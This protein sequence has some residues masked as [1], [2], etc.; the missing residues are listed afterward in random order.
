[1][2]TSCLLEIEHIALISSSNKKKGRSEISW[3]TETV[4]SSGFALLT[5]SV[6]LKYFA[7]FL[8]LCSNFSELSA[9]TLPQEK[10]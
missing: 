4:A 8:L 6:F 3:Q 2:I 10:D 1:M 7:P 9:K 5:P